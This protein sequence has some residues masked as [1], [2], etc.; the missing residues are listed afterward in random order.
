MWVGYVLLSLRDSLYP[1]SVSDPYIYIILWGF[2]IDESFVYNVYMCV[3]MVL[4]FFG[5]IDEFWDSS[6]VEELCNSIC[7]T[8]EINWIIAWGYASLSMGKFDVSDICMF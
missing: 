7:V 5:C 8:N 3:R 1:L 6:V 2:R 4:W